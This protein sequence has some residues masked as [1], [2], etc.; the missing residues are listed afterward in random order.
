MKRILFYTANGV[1]LGHLQRCRLIA[2][3]IQ[4]NNAEII[5]VTSAFSP[6]IFG[7]FFNYLIL[8]TPLSDKL[9]SN[10]SKTRKTRLANNKK[11]AQA[12]K[13]F[14]PNIIVAD[15]YLTSP[16]TFS[17]FKYALDQFPVR[18]I[19]IWR[20]GD[21]QKFYKDFNDENC[22]LDYF[23]K[24]IL[25]HS[26]R[27]LTNLLPLSLFKRIKNSDRFKMIGPIFKKIDKSKIAFCRKKYKIYFQDFLIV[28]TLGGGGKLKKGQCDAPE[29]IIKDFLSIYPRL[30]KAIP[31]LKV[32][33][34][35]G[36]YLRNLNKKSSRQLKFIKFEKNFPELIKLSKM[37][38]STAGYNTCHELIAAKTPAVLIPLMRGDKEQ[39]ERAD[40]FEKRG[41]VKIYKSTSSKNL[42]KAILYCRDNLKKMENNF[43]RFSDWKQGNNEAVKEI[44]KTLDE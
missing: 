30:V 16:F 42:L 39:F 7:K 20:L 27:E 29:K 12:L 40:Y 4:S 2:E 31:N 18:S 14:K 23:Q 10:P 26:Q 35:T 3:K 8:L 5:L 6:Q 28:I 33:V 44:L 36:P 13:K 21:S 41:V 43:R 32:V 19:F 9:L 15:F 34:S 22:R 25:P 38:I 17:S 11:F 37:V 24:I 1:G